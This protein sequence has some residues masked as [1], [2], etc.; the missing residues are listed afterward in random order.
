MNPGQQT[1]RGSSGSGPCCTRVNLPVLMDDAQL[2]TEQLGISRLDEVVVYDPASF[3]ISYRGPVQAEAATA[4]QQ[5]IDDVDADLVAIDWQWC[6]HYYK[7]L[8]SMRIFL[9]PTTLRQSLLRTVQNVTAKVVL[10]HSRWT[11][12]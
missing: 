12:S 5:L 6:C 2:V 1:D 11:A 10:L 3:E 9:T 8:Q 7:R 4:I